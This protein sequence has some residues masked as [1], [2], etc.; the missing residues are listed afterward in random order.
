MGLPAFC[1]RYADYFRGI[2]RIARHEAKQAR[3]LIMGHLGLSSK[4]HYLEDV[5]K[6]SHGST[7]HADLLRRYEGN[8]QLEQAGVCP[9]MLTLAA[10]V[11]DTARPRA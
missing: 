8:P 5:I 3:G 2:A 9:Q 4:V 11:V 7:G 6:M 10:A 1:F